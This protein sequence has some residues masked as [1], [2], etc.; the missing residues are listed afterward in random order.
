MGAIKEDAK[1]SHYCDCPV[2]WRLW[3]HDLTIG[4]FFLSIHS[5][6]SALPNKVA[7]SHM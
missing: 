4:L 6:P 5:I 1:G 7:F 2:T 3:L